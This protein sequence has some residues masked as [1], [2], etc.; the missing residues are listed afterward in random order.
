[1]R[2]TLWRSSASTSASWTAGSNWRRQEAAALVDEARQAAEALRAQA[3]T[4][5]HEEVEHLRE[6]ASRILERALA[7]TRDE[8]GRRIEA[9][10]RQGER[11]Q[12][13][14][15]AWLLSRVTGRDTP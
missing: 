10:R 14:A 11:N 8:T 9:L 13:Q 5:L 2:R 15:V 4:E 6:E 7:D 12:E 1:M 3:E